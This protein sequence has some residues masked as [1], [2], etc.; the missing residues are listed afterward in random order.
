MPQLACTELTGAAAGGVKFL[1]MFLSPQLRQRSVRSAIEKMRVGDGNIW[2][3]VPCVCCPVT[4]AAIRLAQPR[5]YT[6]NI[7]LLPAYIH[8]LYVVVTLVGL[9]CNLDY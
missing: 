7:S 1:L 8:A 4:S 9:L 5:P 6:H 2:S 3:A